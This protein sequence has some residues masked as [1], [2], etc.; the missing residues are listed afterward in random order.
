MN[1]NFY[2]PDGPRLS[3]RQTDA[4]A[5][6]Y[7]AQAY[8]GAD[9]RGTSGAFTKK[10]MSRSGGQ[11]SLGAVVGARAFADNTLKAN[12]A[13]MGDAYSNAN[14]QLQET[15]G[16]ERFGTALA[17]LAEDRQDSD[18]NTRM[19]MFQQG[20]NLLNGLFG[21]MGGSR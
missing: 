6:Q 7:T 5:N 14:A 11:D 1:V 4:A 18:W 12:Q 9:A 13:R 10:G 2:Q 20:Y 3:K 16:R 15:A 17:G 21:G 8:Q 19:D